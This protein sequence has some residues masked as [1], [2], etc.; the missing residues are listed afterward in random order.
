MGPI[1]GWSV[2]TKSG[3]RI[4]Q[5]TVALSAEVEA[6][7]RVK[8][9]NPDIEVHSRHPLAADIIAQL[10]L[11][12]GDITEWVPLDCKEKLRLVTSMTREPPEVRPALQLPG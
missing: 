9:D 3:E 10:G 1:G 2:W 5:F 8:A 11:T 4:R 7:A 12:G 6:V